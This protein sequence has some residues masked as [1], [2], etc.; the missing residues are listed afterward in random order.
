VNTKSERDSATGSGQKPALITPQ[1]IAE[2]RARRKIG[3]VADWRQCDGDVLS[4]AVAAVTSSGAALLFGY[5]RDGGAYSI[6]FLNGG[7][8]KKEYVPATADITE[9]MRGVA[10]DYEEV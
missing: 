5:T 4:R 9:F 8:Q 6:V 1:A 2:R 10:E 7:V 3:V